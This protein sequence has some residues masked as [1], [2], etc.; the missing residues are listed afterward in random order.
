MRD[1]R[2]AAPLAR[3]ADPP[4]DAQACLQERVGELGDVVDKWV[5]FGGVMLSIGPLALPPRPVGAT[6]ESRKFA[7]PRSKRLEYDLAVLRGTA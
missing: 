2:L 6:P 4:P 1:N 3:T 7:E 5:K